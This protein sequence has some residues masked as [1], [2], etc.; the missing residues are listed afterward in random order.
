MNDV[1]I[2]ESVT[3][4]GTEWLVSFDGPNPDDDKC[5]RVANA[6][7]AAKLKRL[8]DGAQVA[9][10]TAML[11]QLGGDGA[12]HTLNG[13][14]AKTVADSMFAFSQWLE[15]RARCDALVDTLKAIDPSAFVTFMQTTGEER[16]KNNYEEWRGEISDVEV[17]R[18]HEAMLREA[19]VDAMRAIRGDIE[20]LGALK[21]AEIAP[22]IQ[23]FMDLFGADVP[24]SPSAKAANILAA[25]RKFREAWRP[26]QS[27]TPDQAESDVGDAARLTLFD[28]ELALAMAI[29]GRGLDQL[30]A[31]LTDPKQEKSR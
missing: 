10:L 31:N 12:Y 17:E 29:D 15:A 18:R 4:A 7:E 14:D 21:S 30:R 19:I 25:A 6:E 24:Q 23:G 5:I 13:H 8:V 2:I 27:M 22:V 20:S 28:A 9:P 11:D 26:F 16:G 1:V 3:E